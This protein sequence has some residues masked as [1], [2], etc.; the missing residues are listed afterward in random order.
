LFVI[1]LQVEYLDE[2]KQQGAAKWIQERVARANEHL[3]EAEQILG[4]C[5]IQYFLAQFKE[6]CQLKLM[7]ARAVEQILILSETA[8]LL[9]ARLDDLNV[10]LLALA[11]EGL[12]V[13]ASSELK[14]NIDETKEA[15]H[16]A[17]NNVA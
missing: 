3:F 9:A 13:T 16:K 4:D 10:K 6:Q 8:D 11:K 14:T 7:G 15:L 12:E 5:L 17:R 1:D 2:M